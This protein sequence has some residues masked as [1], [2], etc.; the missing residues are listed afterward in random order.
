MSKR[1]LIVDD[2]ES[3]AFFLRE[4][5]L[6]AQAGYWVEVANSSEEALSKIA[7]QPFDLV[8]TDLRMPGMD[9][10][11]LM[12]VIRRQSPR[13]RM[14][15][16][17]AYGDARIERAAYQLGACQYITKPFRVQE[18]VNRV[19]AALVEAQAPGRE[20]L[21]LA[22]EQFGDLSRCLTDLRFEVGAQ[23]ILLANVTGQL[24]THVGPTEDLELASLVPLI[25]GGFA[26]AFEMAHYLGD[27]QPTTLN[28]YE[29]QRYDVYSANVDSNLFVVLVF[30]KHEQRS[31][32]GMVWLY[33]RRALRRLQELVGATE[34]IVAEQVLDGDFSSLL[35]DSL[36]QLIAPTTTETDSETK[37]ELT[38]AEANA[39][40][41]EDISAIP[42]TKTLN[43]QQA[44]ELGLLKTLPWDDSETPH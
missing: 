2:E 17:T 18:L 38:L 37:P 24:L 14:I 22:D 12:E 41:Q 40:L 30:D 39:R 4:H 21:A 7:S 42:P 32:I 11:E 10:L 31:R 36:D 34:P 28:Y 20:V 26:T 29:G 25:A 33:T 23:C 35:S 5:L 27:T 9:G 44:K 8:I 6:E 19:H 16:M 15:L 1:I 13:T 3:V 43:W